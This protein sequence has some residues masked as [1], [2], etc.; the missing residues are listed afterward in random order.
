MNQTGKATQLPATYPDSNFWGNTNQVTFRNERD[1]FLAKA[2][3]HEAAHLAVLRHFGG[4]GIMFIWER[5]EPP[6]H[7]Y[8][9]LGKVAITD[10]RRLTPH[11]LKL[12]A[13][14]GTVAEYLARDLEFDAVDIYEMVECGAESLSDSDAE[15]AGNYTARDFYKVAGL[16]ETI[17]PKVEQ[18]A[19]DAI[20][21][22]EVGIAA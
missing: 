8:P 14:A 5:D 10:H 15:M 9:F 17:W 19:S 13:L 6:R 20:A 22:F 21:Q 1:Y 12:V 18:I 4:D 2:C 11:R 7:E 16:L 3:Y